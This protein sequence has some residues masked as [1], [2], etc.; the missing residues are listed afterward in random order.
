MD[1]KATS[2][3]EEIIALD[4][5][6]QDGYKRQMEIYQW[7]LRGNGYKVSDTGYFVYCN[8]RA[9]MEKFDGRLEFN[10]TLIP[11]E[12]KD[13]WID[14]VIKQIKT[15]LDSDTVPAAGKDCDFC[16]YREAA[17]KSIISKENKL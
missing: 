12:G 5:D 17:G 4:K 1:Y 14:A 15:C 8:G 7:L 9:N 3:N 10:L 2:K 11:Y 13:A 16:A 6:W